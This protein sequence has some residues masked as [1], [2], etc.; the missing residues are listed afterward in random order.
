MYTWLKCDI[1]KRIAFVIC[2]I[3]PFEISLVVLIRENRRC[4]ANREGPYFFS[5][6]SRDRI[7]MGLHRE[8]R[9]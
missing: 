2:P 1:V 4:Q 7:S 6:Y 9:K 5:R 3:L 8:A